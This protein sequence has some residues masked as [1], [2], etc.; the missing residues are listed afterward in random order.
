MLDSLSVDTFRH[1]GEPTLDLYLALEASTLA[2]SLGPIESVQEQCQPLNSLD[3]KHAII[4]LN[5]TLTKHEALAESGFTSSTLDRDGSTKR[6]VIRDLI[7]NY[8]CGSLNETIFAMNSA[9]SEVNEF[10]RGFRFFCRGRKI[11][12]YR[13]P[14]QDAK[15]RLLKPYF[16]L[17]RK[18]PKQ[19][20][21]IS[22]SNRIFVRN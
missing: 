15:T 22:T 12:K 21:R 7:E 16:S 20:T 9:L 10:F 19:A 11:K 4:A 3:K 1:R 14:F 5:R 8:N 2:K 13:R 6:T 17:F 18:F